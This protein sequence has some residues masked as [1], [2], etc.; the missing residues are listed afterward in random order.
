MQIHQADTGFGVTIPVPVDGLQG[1]DGRVDHL[2]GVVGWGGQTSAV[3]GMILWFVPVAV[4]ADENLHG[5]RD[6]AVFPE[7]FGGTGG[8]EGNGRP[9][10]IHRG[11]RLSERARGLDA[12]SGRTPG[13]QWKTHLAAKFPDG[14]LDLDAESPAQAFGVGVAQLSH[15][16]NLQRLKSLGDFAADAPD[17]I[18]R[19]SAKM[20]VIILLGKQFE[21]ADTMQFRGLFGDMVGEFR[22]GFG[23]GDPHTNRYA[24]L[25]CGGG[26]HGG[27]HARLLIVGD[28]REVQK[29][30]V[31]AVHLLL[32]G[33]PPQN[34]H[35]AFAHVGIEGIVAGQGDD[36][37][38]G[39]TQLPLKPG[40]AHGNADGF[41][42]GGPGNNASVI[43]GQNNDGSVPELGLEDPLTR[44]IEIVAVDQ[45]DGHTICWFPGFASAT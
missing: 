11:N 18:H 34:A 13:L 40:R 21:M 17:V 29:T 5:A 6:T 16:S 44:D 36:A 35:H 38:S 15:G 31:D 42:F 14:S 10:V 7:F 33:K 19:P 25:P 27:R 23:A 12:V 20:G 8:V 28:A 1:G 9:Q 39:G 45:G 3:D 41:G 24:N 22:A 32:W 2:Q 4:S 37:E 26:A 43:I 30:F